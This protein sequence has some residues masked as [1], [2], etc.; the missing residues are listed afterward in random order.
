MIP[1]EYANAEYELWNAILVFSNNQDAT[2]H[3]ELAEDVSMAI[4]NLT[5]LA[6][7]RGKEYHN[8]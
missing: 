5:N 2:Q 1:D 3:S 6:Y 7:L 4:I 8:A